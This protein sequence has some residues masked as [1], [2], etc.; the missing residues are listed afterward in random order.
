MRCVDCQREIS[1]GVQLTENSSMCHKCY[2]ATMKRYWKEKRATEGKYPEVFVPTPEELWERIEAVRRAIGNSPHNGKPTGYLPKS[3]LTPAEIQVQRTPYG[4]G[5]SN[6]GTLEDERGLY[7][8]VMQVA[9]DRIV[10][11]GRRL[12]KALENMFP[13]TVY[14]KGPTPESAYR[15]AWMQRQD[16]TGMTV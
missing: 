11:S 14:G 7:Y 4:D 15:M 16:Q 2:N 10:Y 12:F 9:N 8:C 1:E 6:I 13:G 3:M 5:K